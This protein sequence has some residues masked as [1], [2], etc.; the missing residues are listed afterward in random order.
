MSA[1][2]Q[3]I[4]GV[5]AGDTDSVRALVT[6][7]I[8]LEEASNLSS[9]RV[10]ALEARNS[11]LEAQVQ[12]L[13]S[14]PPAVGVAAVG[15]SAGRIDVTDPHHATPPPDATLPATEQQMAKLAT[16]RLAAECTLAQLKAMGQVMGLKM[17]G[18]SSREAK[19]AGYTCAEMRT[20]GYTCSDVRTAGYDKIEE[21]I[22]VGFT[23]AWPFS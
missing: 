3:L 4:A 10:E 11:Q 22:D 7:L 5:A 20:A 2:K 17:A 16:E 13:L 1:T 14:H 15:T 12:A 8:A 6:R 21:A 23:Y 18:V 9:S 19:H